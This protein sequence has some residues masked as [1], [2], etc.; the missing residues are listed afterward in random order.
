MVRATVVVPTC[1]KRDLV[2]EAIGS[3]MVQSVRDFEIV[4]VDDGSTDGTPIEIF[5][6]FGAQPRAVEALKRF[7]PAAIK[8][9]SHFFTHEGVAVQYHYNTNRGL[10]AARNRGIRRARGPYIAFLEAEDLW[11]RV[12]LESQLTF[13]QTNPWVRV[14]RVGE[15]S[16]K[17]PCRARRPRKTEKTSGW[18]F[19]N[20]LEACPQTISCAVVHRSCFVECGAFDENLPACEDYDFWL[21][22]AARFP[23][24]YVEGAQVTRRSPR[25]E[26]A[27]RSWTWDRFRVY[28]LEKSFQSGHLDAEQRFLVSQEIVHKCE[29]LVEGFK[30]QNSEERANFYERKRFAQEVRKLRASQG[31]G[32][33]SALR[34][35]AGE[36]LARQTEEADC[37]V[38]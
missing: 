37:A 28:A 21:R 36:S 12:H 25:Q 31:A 11:D 10:S 34:L 26:S 9:F 19:A 30:R 18:V 35:P 8:P 15:R 32:P 4:I 5:T 22:L 1:N 13:L 33:G 29:H 6:A 2:L 20:A 17:E 27:T 7:H 24:Y 38:S 3:A 14:A 16:L 23:I